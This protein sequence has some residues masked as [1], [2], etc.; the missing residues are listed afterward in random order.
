MKLN[1]MISVIDTHTAGEAARLVTAGIPKIPGKDM[2]EKKQYFIEYLDDVR[3]SVMFE[4][5]GH[6]DM[7]GAFLLPPTKEEADFGLVFMDTGGYLNMCGH[8]T[9]AAV[10]AAVETG[11]VDVEE[12]A[13]EKEVVVE[14]PAGLIYATAKLKDNGTKVKEVSFRNVESFLYKRDVELDVEGVGHV[15]FDISF[16]GSFF[17]IISA[18]QLGLEV[19]PENASKLKEAGLKIRDAINANIEIQHPTLAHIKTVDLVEIYDKPSHPE[20]TFKNVVV[21]GDG[22]I[23]RSPCGTGTS[24]KLA[25]LYAKGELKPGEPFVY[26]SILGTLFKGR[27]VEERKLADFDAIIPEITGSGYI[28]GFSNYVY[29]PDDSLTY[30]FLL[31]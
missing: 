1:K 28:L 3:K 23:D 8:N 4:P 29:D 20:A 13:T 12:G 17:C 22:N 15:K 26:E 9:I 18:D 7:F 19:K 2:V 11:M 24:A 25:T 5:R 27:I 16:G 21:F 6:Q 30:G 14:T 10:T 31:G